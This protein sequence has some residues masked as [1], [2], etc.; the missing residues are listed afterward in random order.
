MNWDGII[1]ISRQLLTSGSVWDRES[2]R[3]RRGHLL[4]TAPGI[5]IE[6][7][8]HSVLFH[9]VPSEGFIGNIDDQNIV[10]LL[11]ETL[12]FRAFQNDQCWKYLNYGSY[13]SFYRHNCK[14]QVN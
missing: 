4:L 1:R 5:T 13:F 7:P 3:R 8:C 9:T 14:P 6:Q 11:Q 2:S 10:I 12:H